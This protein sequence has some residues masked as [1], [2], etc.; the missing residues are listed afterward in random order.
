MSALCQLAGSIAWPVRWSRWDTGSKHS[1]W[2]LGPSEAP[3]SVSDGGLFAG[4]R[5]ADRRWT[6]PVASDWKRS[7]TA[8]TNCADLVRDVNQAQAVKEASWQSPV[9]ADGGSTSRGGDRKGELLL[10]GQVREANWQTSRAREHG[11]YQRDRGDPTKP[12]ASQLGQVK[13]ANWQTCVCED[14]EQ[15][16]SAARGPSQ[17]S[18][19]RESAWQTPVASGHHTRKQVNGLHRQE[20]LPAQVIRAA[21]PTPDGASSMPTGATEQ[22]RRRSTNGSRAGSTQAPARSAPNGGSP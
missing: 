22:S 9:G 18:Q 19:V 16:G 2:A 3:K 21:G 14:K 10:G 17:T 6:G 1:A 4:E 5:T 13:A 20:L 8:G 12:R 11:D 7:G 15:S